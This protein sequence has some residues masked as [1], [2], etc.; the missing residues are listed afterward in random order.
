MENPMMEHKDLRLQLNKVRAADVPQRDQI[1]WEGYSHLLTGAIEDTMGAANNCNLKGI[2]RDNLPQVQEWLTI[3]DGTAKEYAD[4]ANI[5]LNIENLNDDLVEA[6]VS[7][8]NLKC[9][10]Q[11][12]EFEKWQTIK[13]EED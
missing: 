9:G 4:A 1:K 7:T 8:L 3:L 5:R 6:I 13:K 10:C 12:G 11:L 2:I